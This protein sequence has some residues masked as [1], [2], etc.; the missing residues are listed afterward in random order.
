MKIVSS[1]LRNYRY[2]QVRGIHP[3]KQCVFRPALS[4]LDMLFVMRRLQQL[5]RDSKI[6]FYTCFIDLRKVYDTVD[7]ELLWEI[8]FVAS[9]S[10]CPDCPAV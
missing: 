3:E 1:R 4:A 6:P 2:C 9:K 8:L 5:G 7:R 10:G